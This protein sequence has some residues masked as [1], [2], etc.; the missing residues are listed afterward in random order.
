MDLGEIDLGEF[1]RQLFLKILQETS[2]E[3]EFHELLKRCKDKQKQYNDESFPP[4][5][6]SLITYWEDESVRDKVQKWK[7]FIWKRAS[8][9]MDPD[10]MCIFKDKIEPDDVKQGVL[11]DCYFMSS[12]SVLAEQPERIIELFES[13]EVNEYGLYAIRL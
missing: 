12:L 6:S 10:Q 13:H 8:E 2:S 3:G 11:G 1:G 7:Y 4:N 9:F 5:R